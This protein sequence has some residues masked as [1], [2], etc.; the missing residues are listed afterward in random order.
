MSVFTPLQHA[1]LAVFVAPYQLGRLLAFE[2]IAAGTENSNFFVSLEAG[3]CVLTLIERPERQATLGF[4]VALLDRLDAAGLKVPHALR[5]REGRA[6]GELAG[7]PALLQPRLPGRHVLQPGV[8]HCRAIGDWLGRL[9]QLTREAA[10][11]QPNDRGFDWILEVGPLQALSLPEAERALLAET[12]AELAGERQHL[13][14]LPQANLHGDL[15]CDNALFE[16][17]ELSGVLDFHNA[18]LGPMLLDLAIVANDWCSEPDGR[19]DAPRLS[20][21]LGAYGAH[22]PFVAREALLWPLVLRAAA[23]RFWL[24]RLIAA[25]ANAGQAVLIKDPG[26]FRQRLEQRRVAVPGLPFAL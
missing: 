13:E 3:E 22:R 15:F 24:S 16:G 7:L 14:S 26:E 2:G 19:L 6:I 21:L 12:L 4:V 1:E 23:L 5:T 17:A 18:C 25:Q 20:A 9:H 8:A 10:L 11:E